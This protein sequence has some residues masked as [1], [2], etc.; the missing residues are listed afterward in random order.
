M[1]SAVD[2]NDSS[3]GYTTPLDL[4]SRLLHSIEQVTHSLVHPTLGCTEDLKVDAEQIYHLKENI[5]CSLYTLRQ[6]HNALRPINQLPPKILGLIFKFTQDGFVDRVLS[7]RW[8][9]REPKE[10]GPYRD[11]YLPTHVCQYF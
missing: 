5:H 9:T 1:S 3:I 11:V 2:A 7:K 10:L 8:R 6:L 4:S